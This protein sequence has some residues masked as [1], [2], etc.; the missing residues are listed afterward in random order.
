M[1]KYFELANA[2]VGANTTTDVPS[3]NSL[4]DNLQGA[5]AAPAESLAQTR[6][7]ARQKII[8]P[9]SDPRLLIPEHEAN[10]VYV[11]EAMRG[12]RTRVLRLHATK[13]IKSF[14]LTSSVAGEGK[15]L[16]ASNLSIS[17]AQLIYHRTLLIDADLRSGGAS[18]LLGATGTVGLTQVLLGKA[19]PEEAVCA[20]NIPN[21]FVMGTGDP[22]ELSPA[23]LFV[24]DKWKKI[25]NWAAESFKLVFV[26]APPVVGLADS[27][28]LAT[29]V[30][31]V[32][33][34]VRSNAAPRELVEK[35]IKHLDS[36]K[37]LGLVFNGDHDPIHR[38]HQKYGY[39]YGYGYGHR[40]PAPK[41]TT[42]KVKK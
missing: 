33:F 22:A 24:G 4:L 5:V 20:T 34:I 40:S 42:E 36:K 23:E 38:R 9:T 7:A 28:I 41:T 30:D 13:G 10:A 39:G 21:L 32:L 2:A 3:L 18:R 27:E 31:G 12:L 19:T 16:T 26:D 1:S 35:A 15:T 17:C 8:I 14:M 37:L 25:L 11:V 6:V 29:A